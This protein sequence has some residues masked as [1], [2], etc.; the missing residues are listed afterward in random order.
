[1]SLSKL[2]LLKLAILDNRSHRP[3]NVVE[4]ARGVQ[5]LSPHIPVKDRLDVVA[6]LL[7]FPPNRKVYSKI[8]ALGRLPEVVLA[9]LLR[10]TLSL[11]AGADLSRLPPEEATAFFQVLEGLK[12]SQNKQREIIRLAQEIAIRED[13][14]SAQVLQSTDLRAILDS[15]ELNRNEKGAMLRA[16]L[17]RRRFPALVKAEE[18]VLKELK[19]LKLNEY[20][21]ITPPPYFEGDSYTL[22]MT[23]KNLEGFHQRRETLN[24]LGK[25]PALKR[26]LQPY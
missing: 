19:A 22:S 2:E 6:P 26:L 10:G 12:L 25:N 8:S 7:G 15:H 1:T 18:K 11:E 21:R 24:A 14:G 16:Y 23:F 20:V 4:Q 17:K 9:G 13:L 3:L 5:K